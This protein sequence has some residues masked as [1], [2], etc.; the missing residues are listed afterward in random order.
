MQ[1]NI[2]STALALT[3]GMVSTVT[4]D[5]SDQKWMT[6]VEISKEGMHCSDD[7]NCLNRYHPDV[8]SKA[9]ANIGDMIIFHTRDA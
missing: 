6:K 8:P 1:Y 5:T 9:S 4:A 3:I 2:F 7:V